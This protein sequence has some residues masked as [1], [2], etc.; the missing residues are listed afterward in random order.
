MERFYYCCSHSTDLWKLSTLL[1]IDH[2]L[3]SIY[4]NNFKLLFC[5]LDYNHI[6][7]WFFWTQIPIFHRCCAV[8][9]TT[10][11][12]ID[13]DLLPWLRD[14]WFRLIPFHSL[15]GHSFRDFSIWPK[16]NKLRQQ[17]L[18]TL[19]SKVI[20]ILIFI[21]EGEDLPWIWEIPPGRKLK[22]K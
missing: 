19:R 18:L 9:W 10:C 21:A 2:I 5:S 4:E 17:S 20:E 13:S 8:S 15:G 12:T 22:S 6:N 11:T 7:I 3:T 16:L 14:T 1:S